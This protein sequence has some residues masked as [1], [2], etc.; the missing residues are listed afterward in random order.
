M[1]KHE[2]IFAKKQ[3]NTQNLENI[4]EN[5]TLRNLESTESSYIDSVTSTE[6]KGILK[7]EQR[8]N[9]NNAEFGESKADLKSKALQNLA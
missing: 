9:L 2:P 7:N 3:S 8:Q 6:S 4:R 5:A 1:R